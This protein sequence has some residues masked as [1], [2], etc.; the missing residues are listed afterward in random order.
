MNLKLL[1][2][3]SVAVLIGY[4]ALFHIIE[5]WH[6]MKA[7]KRPPLP[8]PSFRTKVIRFQDEQGRDVVRESQFQVSTQLADEATLKKLPPPP[9]PIPAAEAP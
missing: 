3:V 9:K 4:L 6:D 2:C 5:V 8:E 7:P 1:A